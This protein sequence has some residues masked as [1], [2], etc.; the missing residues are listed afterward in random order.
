MQDICNKSKQKLFFIASIKCKDT[1]QQFEKYQKKNIVHD[2]SSITFQPNSKMVQ[3]LSKLSCLGRIEH[4]IHT[5]TVR[6]NPDQVIRIDGKSEYDV[7][8]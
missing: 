6:G 2:K 8:L 4:S 5:F 7:R 1:I 3:Y